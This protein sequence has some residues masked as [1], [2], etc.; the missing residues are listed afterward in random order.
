MKRSLPDE[1]ARHERSAWASAVHVLL[2]GWRLSTSAAWLA[3]C[4]PRQKRAGRET[5]REVK[6]LT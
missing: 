4:W 3:R 5:L 1:C 2:L 6:M